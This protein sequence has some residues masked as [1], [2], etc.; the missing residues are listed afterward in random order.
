MK[1]HKTILLVQAI[2]LVLVLTALY[3]YYPRADVNINGEWVQFNSINANVIMIS[4]NP[5]FSNPRYIDLSERK[6]LTFNL[7]P[8]TY[9]WKSENGLISGWK[10]EFTINSEVGISLNE[11]EDVT[12]LVNSGNV[13]INVSRDKDGV[14]VGHIILEPDKDSEIDNS[15]EYIG[16][17]EG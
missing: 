9:Y 16:R 1:K 2:F 6:N 12:K 15:G 7:E 17:Q 3:F 11:S 13:R 5:D 4:E 8:G 10:K 14:L